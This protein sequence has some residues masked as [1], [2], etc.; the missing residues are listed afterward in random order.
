MNLN[1]NT[2]GSPAFQLKPCNS[3]SS[4]STIDKL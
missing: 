3:E 1:H 4:E 2:Y